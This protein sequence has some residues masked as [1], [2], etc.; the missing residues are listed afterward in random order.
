MTTI[1][2]GAFMESRVI[3][4]D[5]TLPSVETIGEKAFQEAHIGAYLKFTDAP[6][7]QLK[8][9]TFQN[10]H[11]SYKKS[12]SFKGCSLEQIGEDVYNERNLSVLIETNKC[13]DIGRGNP[14]IGYWMVKESYFSPFLTTIP[15][16]LNPYVKSLPPT[17]TAIKSG[18][19]TD[20][21]SNFRLSTSLK[22]IAVDAFPKGSTF[23]VDAG[24]YAELWCS[25][26]GFGYS[27]EGQ[28]N[29]DWLNN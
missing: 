17:V 7:K 21:V 2:V 28:N 29:L 12:I 3:N 27:I 20:V 9:K 8:D 22:D 14:G 15:A 23:I 10:V 24:S 13:N 5:L 25:E 4:E 11:V 6:I 26:N 18:A 19:Y 1:G 16:G